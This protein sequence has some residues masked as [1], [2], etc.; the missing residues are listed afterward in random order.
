MKSNTNA[1]TTITTTYAI[2]RSD[3]SGVL[4]RNA[5][6]HLRN[7]HAAVS[8]ALERVVHLLPFHHV[9]WVRLSTEEISDGGV[10][11]R[12]GLFLEP[13]DLSR[14]LG[15]AFRLPNRGYAGLDMLRSLDEDTRERA[16]GFFDDADV[17]HLE[18]ASGSIDQ[19]DDVVQTRGEHVNVL[20][21]DGR[22]ET[23]ID[24]LIDRTR[25]NVRLV[26][27]VLD[28]AHMIGDVRGIVEQLCQHPRCLGQMRRE[29]IEESKELL[30]AR[31][32]FRQQSHSGLA[33]MAP[34]DTRPMDGVKDRSPRKGPNLWATSGRLALGNALWLLE[35]LDQQHARDEAANVRPYRHAARD[36]GV[37]LR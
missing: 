19:V 30:V 12:V 37:D 13:L 10:I 25:Q 35:N 9:Q 33:E 16:R 2:T 31:N 22:D 21:V 20:T 26:F 11:D 32:Q 23:L 34:E 8:C 17:Q 1:I 6:Q 28:R 24:P 5:L 4:E 14:L 27:Y 15:H 18:A 7:A 29:L 3:A 36:V